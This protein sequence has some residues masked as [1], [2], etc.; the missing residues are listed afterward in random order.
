MT[1]L[2][3]MKHVMVTFFFIILDSQHSG[4]EENLGLPVGSSSYR[5]ELYTG[6]NSG[7]VRC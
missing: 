4:S 1:D 6:K 3:T 2:S 5:S 7:K